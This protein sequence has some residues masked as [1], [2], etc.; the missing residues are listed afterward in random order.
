MSGVDA[1]FLLSSPARDDVAPH[2]NAIDAA[3]RAGVS[4]V[5]RSSLLGADPASGCTFRRQH[6]EADAYL[7]ASGVPFTVLRPNYSVLISVRCLTGQA[8]F[9]S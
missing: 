6:G 2:R 8:T 3:R 1:V 7:A 4:R 5:V 9:L